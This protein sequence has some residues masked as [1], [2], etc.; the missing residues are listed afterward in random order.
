[1]G[2]VTIPDDKGFP[3]LEIKRQ[4][5]NDIIRGRLEETLQLVKQKL[6]DGSLEKVGTGVFLTGGSSLMRG[7]GELAN[8]VF[9]LPIYRP[10]QP[11]VSGIHEY[12]RDPQYSTVVGLIRYAQLMD[13]DSAQ[14]KAG[15]LGKLVKAVWPF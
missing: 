12:F 13:E 1:M 11:E 15:V 2:T 10:E 4:L 5:L 6:P 8:D 9:H 3:E 7:F 14:E